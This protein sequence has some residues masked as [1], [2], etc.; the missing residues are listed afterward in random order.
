LITAVTWKWG[1]AYGPQYVNRMRNMLKRNLQ[2]PHRLVC[3]TDDTTGI[4]PGVITLPM[5]TEHAGVMKA[6]GYR[7]ADNDLCQRRLKMFDR[8]MAGVLGPRI[9]HLDLD[10]V[11]T[12]DI[13]SLIDRPDPLIMYGHPQRK[14][15]VMPGMMLFNAG[16]LHDLYAGFKGDAVRS[17]MELLDRYLRE[18]QLMPVPRWTVEDGAYSHLWIAK[19]NGGKLPENAKVVMFYGP[20]NPHMVTYPWVNTNWR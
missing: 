15:G 18:K 17:D 16:Y 9:L 20:T 14:D 10:T 6:T 8:N 3:I 5:Y 19:K 11:I 13:T 2:L 7:S 1:T 12:G 4:G